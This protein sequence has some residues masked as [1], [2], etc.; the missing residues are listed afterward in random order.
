VG[1]RG[2]RIACD[3]LAVGRDRSVE[4]FFLEEIPTSLL[5][6][7]DRLLGV[8]GRSDEAGAGDGEKKDDRPRRCLFLRRS[9]QEPKDRG[10]HR[11]LVD[12]VSFRISSS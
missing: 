11:S 4:V 5:E 2:L 1:L 12:D 7:L 8:L 6:L 9:S 3:R 10:S